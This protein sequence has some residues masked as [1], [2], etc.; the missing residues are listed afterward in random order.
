[1]R[2]ESADEAALVQERLAQEG[3]EAVVLT[4]QG[5]ELT[6]DRQAA[7]RAARYS[8]MTDWCRRA[9]ILHLLL[10]HHRG[11]QAET[12]ML[13]L[14]RGSGVDGLAAMAPVIENAYLRLL[15]P[16]LGVPRDRLLALLA[17]RGMHWVD[18]PSNEDPSF[19][20]VRVRQLLPDLREDGFTEQ[21]LAATAT[22]MG[23]ARAAL[24]A[25]ATALLA[26]AAAIYPEGYATLCG[27]ELIRADEEIGLRALARL[28][29][30][31]GGNR[32]GPRLERLERL[33]GWLSRGVGGGRTLAGCRI[34]R[35]SNGRILIYRE[36]AAS[37]DAVPA[38][39]GCLWDGR[40][41]LSASGPRD[42]KLHRLGP[43]G[44]AQIRS[45]GHLAA[46]K[47]LPAGVRDAI[48][49]IWRLEQVVAVPHLSYRAESLKEEGGE[50][51][52]LAFLPGRSLG[53]ACFSVLPG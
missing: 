42:S 33:Y 4:R 15:R 50:G 41:R 26:R 48:P 52:E 10:G 18:D 5:A 44:W 38:T 12:L 53:G 40:F 3:I 19:A 2:A 21:R 16:L 35:R 20:R 47:M 24:E 34:V 7:A 22:R 30:C 23:R 25:A 37:R 14:G 8:L 49:A 11:D 6:S 31:I 32:H 28:L 39:A 36:A 13:R 27:A 17:S 9:G 43:D 1:M 51:M 46:A 29:V 45:D